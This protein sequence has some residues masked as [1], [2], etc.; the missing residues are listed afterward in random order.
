MGRPSWVLL[1]ASVQIL[2]GTFPLSC[3]GKPSTLHALHSHCAPSV[4]NYI[5][6]FQALFTMNG[7]QRST[8]MTASLV[9][10]H[11]LLWVFT[12]GSSWGPPGPRASSGRGPEV[13]FTRF[14]FCVDAPGAH[15]AFPGTDIPSAPSLLRPCF[16]RQMVSLIPCHG[17]LRS[18]SCAP[19]VPVVHE[20]RP[21][22]RGCCVAVRSVGKARIQGFH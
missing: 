2:P 13:R 20:G 21:T 15:A 3:W 12:T 8:A 19:K 7:K 17:S 6:P 4:R 14:R 1:W 18:V 5:F 16:G 9:D 22:C 11:Q 10:R